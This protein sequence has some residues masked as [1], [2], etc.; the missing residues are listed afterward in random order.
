MKCVVPGQDIFASL[1]NGKSFTKLDL[2]HT[3]QQL[4]LDTD[5]CFTSEEFAAFVRANGVKHLTSAPYHPA[6]NGLAERAVQ[7]LKNALKKDPGKTNL[8]TQMLHFLFRYRI[9]PHAFTPLKTVQHRA[10]SAEERHAH[11]AK[12]KQVAARRGPTQ[13]PT[14]A[15]PTIQSMFTAAEAGPGPSRRSGLQQD[16]HPSVDEVSDVWGEFWL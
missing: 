12:A 8:E 13:F 4:P 9:T 2:A 3:Y 5:S 7:T 11:L 14:L 10:V 1:S 6:A 15:Q 16:Y